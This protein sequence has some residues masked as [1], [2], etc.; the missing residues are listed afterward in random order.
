M[1]KLLKDVHQGLTQVQVI[2]RV[3]RRGRGKQIMDRIAEDPPPPISE[4]FTLEQELGAL[5]TAETQR[6][7]QA[8][9]ARGDFHREPPPRQ[10]SSEVF[11]SDSAFS[12]SLTAALEDIR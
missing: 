12:K 10:Q 2:A 11:Q 8:A 6:D 7:T 3:S 9:L 4:I 5:V 1:T